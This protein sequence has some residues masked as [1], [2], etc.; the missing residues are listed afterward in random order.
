MQPVSSASVFNEETN[1]MKPLKFIFPLVAGIL[2]QACTD[3]MCIEGNGNRVRESRSQPDFYGVISQGDFEVFIDID[4]SIIHPEI[5]IEADENLLP[6]I[7][8][9]VRNE[10]L[11][12]YSTNRHC[13]ES[14]GPVIVDICMNYLDYVKLEGSGVIHNDNLSTDQLRLDLTGSGIIEFLNLELSY[15]DV[16]HSGSGRVEASGSCDH[17]DL[18][19]SGSGTIW[20]YHLEQSASNINLSGSGD[21]YAWAWDFLNIDIPGS[22]TVYYRVKPSEFHVHISGSG[23]ARLFNK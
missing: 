19:L 3:F 20:T 6:F 1:P 15:L 13:F 10:N 14:D 9:R 7:G 11:E 22:G 21:I 17:S 5:T 18:D 12:I 2:L 16:R 4:T 8:T 23:E